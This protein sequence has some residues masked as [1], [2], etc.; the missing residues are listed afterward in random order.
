MVLSRAS[1]ANHN[2]VLNL[3]MFSG[4]ATWVGGLE[5]K[6]SAD[7]AL[8]VAVLADSANVNVN[9]APL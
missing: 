5:G 3:Q 1:T 7:E 9:T 8:Q 2:P 4:E 6:N